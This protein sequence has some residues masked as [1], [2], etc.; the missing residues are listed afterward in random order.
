MTNPTKDWPHA[1][2]HQLGNDGVFMVTGATLYKQRLFSG[3]E[4]LDILEGSLLSLVQRVSLATRGMVCLRK[5]LPHH[6]SR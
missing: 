3:R 1:P 4:R 2:V 5:S 6:R